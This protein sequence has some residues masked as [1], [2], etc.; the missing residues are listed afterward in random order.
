MSSARGAST[1]AIVADKLDTEYPEA[2]G[3]RSAKDFPPECMVACLTCVMQVSPSPLEQ[4]LR[5]RSSK[6]NPFLGET[7]ESPGMGS[8]TEEGDDASQRARST[9]VQ[10]TVRKGTW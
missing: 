5:K 10:E 8:D 6:G 2:Q 4:V 3:M 7:S 1:L 9:T